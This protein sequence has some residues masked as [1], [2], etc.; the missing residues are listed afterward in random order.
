MSPMFR[1]KIVKGQLLTFTS[2]DLEQLLRE[3]HLVLSAQA[4]LDSI[5][6]LKQQIHR[7]EKVIK[8]KL[9]LDQAFNGLL[10]VPGKCHRPRNIHTAWSI[11]RALA[12]DPDPAARRSLS[13]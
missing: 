4:N 9:K 13:G 7:L 3:D 2:E 1:R 12:I 11:G 6:F 10:T 8:N 5:S